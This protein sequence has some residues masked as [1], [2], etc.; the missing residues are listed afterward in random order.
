MPEFT[1]QWSVF[2]SKTVN[3]ESDEEAMELVDEWLEDE[4]GLTDQVAAGWDY[5]VE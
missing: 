4:H 3:A 5:R 1:V 2:G